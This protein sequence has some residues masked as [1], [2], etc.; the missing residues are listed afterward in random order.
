ML[1]FSPCSSCRSFGTTLVL[2]DL[3]YNVRP[4]PFV[5]NSSS[6]SLTDP[7]V[8]IS[9]SCPSSVGS[10]TSNHPKSLPKD[11]GTVC[12]GQARGGISSVGGREGR[13]Y[14]ASSDGLCYFATVWCTAVADVRFFCV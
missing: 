7:F 12:N 8:C 14:L 9:G 3:F 13:L 10:N 1:H 6:P 4:T 2:K 11:R 5:R